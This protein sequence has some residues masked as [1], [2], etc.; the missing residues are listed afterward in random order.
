[1]KGLE[2]GLLQHDHSIIPKTIRSMPT[3][4]IITFV[5][6]D[7]DVVHQK[8]MSMKTEIV[9]EPTDMPYGQRRLLV[10]DPEGTILD[11]SAIIKN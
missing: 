8:A 3:G 6:E 5:V 9:E 1:M 11:I 7:S 10:K 2:L 4:V